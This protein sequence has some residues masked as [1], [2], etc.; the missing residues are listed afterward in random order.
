M[1]E[2]EIP[3]GRAKDLRGQKF[4]KLTA[5]Y[6][7]KGPNKKTHWKCQC[8][9]GNIS[10]VAMDNLTRGIVKSCGC[11]K[12]TIYGD[13]TGQRFGNLVCLEE[14]EKMC[15]TGKQW[16][17][18]CDCGNITI[19]SRNHLTQGHTQSC[20]CFQKQRTSDTNSAH[21]IPGTR[22]GKLTIIKE[23]GKKNMQTVWEC[24]C[25]CGNITQVTTGHLNSGHTQSC[26]CLSSQG[27]LKISTLLHQNK[28]IFEIQK[29]FL[30]CQYEDGERSPRFDFYI[31]NHYL[32]EYDGIQHFQPVELFGGEEQFKIQQERDVYKN[33]WCK[34]NNIPLI[35]VP[36]TKLD[37]L[38]IE[39][40]LLETTKFRVV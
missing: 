13:L 24:K 14:V 33:Q 15:A 8:E 11:N 12:G 9:C 6:R 10:I 34:E 30:N 17:C 35:R 19:V 22:Y 38:C 21:L 20:G 23:A 37:T 39:D 5:L 29:T 4:N 26:G 16:K 3:V 1:Y 7:V 25:D 18:R 2:D 31:N 32:I 36:Y 40:L 27:E 28:I